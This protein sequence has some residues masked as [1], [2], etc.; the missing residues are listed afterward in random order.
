M[1]KKGAPYPATVDDFVPLTLQH[2]SREPS[3]TPQSRSAPL[4]DTYA[5]SI[6]VS[7]RLPQAPG[8]EALWKGRILKRMCEAELGLTGWLCSV[9][10]SASEMLSWMGTDG[11]GTGGREEAKRERLCLTVD[12]A[13]WDWSA[14]YVAVQA[15]L[16]QRHTSCGSVVSTWRD[17]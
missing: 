13:L 14:H 1:R 2:P 5:W 10:G 17:C 16:P 9:H 3:S 11:E 8:R 12:C 7:N 4:S 15:C 6:V